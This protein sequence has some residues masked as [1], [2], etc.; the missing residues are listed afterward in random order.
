MKQFIKVGC[1]PEK[2]V[3]GIPAYA[4]HTHNS[5]L[6]KTY[7]EV[8]D[9]Y[10]GDKKLSALDGYHFDTPGEVR[11]KVR[12]A[13]EAGLGGIFFWELGQDNQDSEYEGG[14]LLQTAKDEL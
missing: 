14:E 12:F 11:L 4:R 10:F 6:K 8:V 9:E 2:L 1:P 7:A 13:K 3:M 5:S